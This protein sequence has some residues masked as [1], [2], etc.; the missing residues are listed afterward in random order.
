MTELAYIGPSEL[1]S[2]LEKHGLRLHK[3]WGQHFL[4][5][6]HILEKIIRTVNP[7]PDD[8]V[9]EVGA[10]AGAL[11]APLAQGAGRVVAVEVDRGL[12]PVLREVLARFAVLNRTCLVIQDALKLDW[13]RLLGGHG[14]VFAA[15][16]PY[17]IS[18]PILERILTSGLFRRAVVMLQKDVGMRLTAQPGT[19]DYSSLTLFA[20]YHGR[21]SLAFEVPR[22]AFFPRP[23]VESAVVTI[24]L[25]EGPTVKVSDRQ[26]MFDLI[27]TAFGYRRKQLPNAL[28]RSEQLRDLGV[29]KDRIRQVI[30]SFG[31]GMVRG[32][33]LSLEDFQKLTEEI[34]RLRGV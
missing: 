14:W 32:E 20:R 27:R 21:V 16:L 11:T 24:D 5:D 7:C 4:I 31:W 25:E 3:R 22:G 15:N 9:M 17:N 12:E 1:K 19:R 26:L 28:E 2:L 33:D 10:G 13:D 29:A 34:V 23:Q 18:T 30:D 6:R 8:S